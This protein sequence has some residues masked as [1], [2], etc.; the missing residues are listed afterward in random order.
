MEFKLKFPLNFVRNKQQLSFRHFSEHEKYNA[1]GHTSCCSLCCRLRPL[2]NI[3]LRVL[4]QLLLARRVVVLIPFA[5]QTH[6]YDGSVRPAYCQSIGV[7]QFLEDPSNVSKPSVLWS[8]D[9]Q[10]SVILFLK[11]AYRWPGS[12][13]KAVWLD[14]LV[15]LVLYGFFSTTRRH[16]LTD[17]QRE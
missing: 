5:L 9:E 11:H 17:E 6:S 14:L 15:W 10:F 2:V 8:D 4:L 3:L 7:R 16:M 12:V 1:S 13:Y